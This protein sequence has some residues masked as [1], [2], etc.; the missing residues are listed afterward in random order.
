MGLG[1]NEEERSE[2]QRRSIS[3]VCNDSRWSYCKLWEERSRSSSCLAVGSKLG[4][5]FITT[6][7]GYLCF[8]TAYRRWAERE[9]LPRPVL[10]LLY[11]HRQI[12]ARSRRPRCNYRPRVITSPGITASCRAGANVPFDNRTLPRE[13]ERKREEEGGEERHRRNTEQLNM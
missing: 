12:M 4:R 5:V 2:S 9:C 13:K 8:H 7:C 1:G 11:L 3:H 6:D 10:S